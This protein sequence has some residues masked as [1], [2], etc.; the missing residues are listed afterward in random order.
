MTARMTLRTALIISLIITPN[1]LPNQ[2]VETP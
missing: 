2:K 1:P